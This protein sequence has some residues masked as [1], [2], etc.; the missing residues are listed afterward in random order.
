MRCIFAASTIH[1]RQPQNAVLTMS[2]DESEDEDETS[3]DESE[4]QQPAVPIR[5]KFDDEEDSDDVCSSGSLL[6]LR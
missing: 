4:P 3:S 2:V 5:K 6:E 1:P